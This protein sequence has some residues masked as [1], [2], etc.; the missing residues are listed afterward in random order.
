MLGPLV[1]S[2]IFHLY[3][4]SLELELIF[5]LLG[6]EDVMKVLHLMLIKIYKIIFASHSMSDRGNNL[7]HL[8]TKYLLYKGLYYS[9]KEVYLNDNLF[10][11]ERLHFSPVEL[12]VLAKSLIA[13][14]NNPY[15]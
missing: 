9:N 1:R 5:S 15:Y 14:T 12:S 10:R 2:L 8:F 4:S 6:A 11:K 7:N 13:V 3:L